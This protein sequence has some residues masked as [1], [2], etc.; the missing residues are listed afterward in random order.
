MEVVLP[1][2]TPEVLPV[3]PDQPKLD[4]PTAAT[5][6][7]QVECST[8]KKPAKRKR[9]AAAISSH[10]ECTRCTQRK[11]KDP[12]APPSPWSLF[13]KKFRLENP[14]LSSGESLVQARKRY[15][16]PSGR[17]KSFEVIFREVWQAR[18]PNWKE[19]FPKSS[20]STEFKD[21]LRDAFLAAI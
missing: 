4:P 15:V 6:E 13:L 16:P 1:A 2:T 7:P 18:H 11:K 17:K 12:N 14:G 9:S 8:E 10:P 5:F 21:K 3:Q 19:E 20:G